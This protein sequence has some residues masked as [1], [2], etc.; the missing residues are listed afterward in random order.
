MKKLV[1]AL[2]L[3]LLLSACTLRFGNT[4]VSPSQ[5]A[6]TGF[7]FTLV[8]NCPAEQGPMRLHI[9]Q[10]AY[11]RESLDS[12]QSYT[13]TFPTG[14]YEIK[15]WLSNADL[16]FFDFIIAPDGEMTYYARVACGGTETPIT[17]YLANNCVGVDPTDGHANTVWHWTLQMV[18]PAE[19]DGE[20][21]DPVELV[22]PL[23]ESV[24]GELPG[25]MY[26]VRDWTENGSVDHETYVAPSSGIGYIYVNLCMDNDPLPD[27]PVNTNQP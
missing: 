24:S 27:A 23:G 8:N 1:F 5:T 20:L 26:A 7:S 10:D 16:D 2:L 9:D 11:V 18:A 3:I 25:G 21:I 22:I 19:Q 13:N 12:G 4:T 17:Y 15:Y 14:S 6:D